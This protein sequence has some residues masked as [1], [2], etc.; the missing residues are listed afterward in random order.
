MR[1][2]M[3][4]QLRLRLPLSQLK[5]HPPPLILHLLLRVLHLRDRLEPLAAPQAA[6]PRLQLILPLL[7]SHR[8]PA[9]PLSH[10]HP[11]RPPPL[12]H[13]LI[14][15]LVQQVTIKHGNQDTIGG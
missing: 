10:R 3:D 11:L 1:F 12:R 4:L 5:L 9:H 7:L 6:P 15:L 13:Q 2:N 14:R 8:H